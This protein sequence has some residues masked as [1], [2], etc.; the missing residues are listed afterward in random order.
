VQCKQVQTHV[1]F[2]HPQAIAAIQQQQQLQR[3]MLAQQTSAA[4]LAM[5]AAQQQQQALAAAQA[6]SAQPSLNEFALDAP[7]SQVRA[8]SFELQGS[9]PRYRP[10]AV[11]KYFLLLLDLERCKQP[12]HKE[13]T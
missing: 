5:L 3:Q 1:S 6:V 7:P 8:W 12:L 13:P 4:Q 9:V 11:G 2:A 10:S